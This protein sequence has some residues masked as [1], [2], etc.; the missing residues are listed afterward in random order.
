VHRYQHS[1]FVL[2]SYNDDQKKSHTDYIQ[3]SMQ[4]QFN[5]RTLM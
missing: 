3:L 1:Y 5:K 2:R 4:T